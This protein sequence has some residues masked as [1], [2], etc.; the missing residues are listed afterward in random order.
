MRIAFYA[1]MKPPDDPSPSGDRLMARQ[2]LAALA[3]GGH[4]ARIV[5]RLRAWRATP[6][7]EAFA[8]LGTE[9]EAERARLAADFAAPGA[10]APDLWLTYHLYYRAPDLIGPTLAHVRR[11]PYVA[12]EASHAPKRETGPWAAQAAAARAALTGASL[13]LALTQRDRAGLAALPG[14]PPVGLF[15]PFLA[16]AGPEPPR[17]ARAGPARLVT[18]AMMRDDRKARSWAMLAEALARIAGLDWRI[19][20]AG[21]GAGRA[22]VEAAFAPLA[23]R[24]T[25]LGQL[26]AAGTRAALDRADIFVWPG[27]REAYG[28]VYLE[29]AARG[30][31]V[32]AMASGGV[33]EATRAGETALLTADEDIDAYAAAIARLIADP[34]LA[35]RLGAAGRRFAAGERSL[36]AAAAAL[37]AHLTNAITRGAKP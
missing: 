36:T 12:V 20:L 3:A 26:D 15:P 31:P 23:G 11:I 8:A 14:G 30:L 4:D 2:L 35:A 32:V 33:G 13:L 27:H 24:V 7:A 21:D 5:S 16:E 34:A 9:A 28:M 1:P 22:A 25:F 37:D 6:D 19:E 17:R 10:W 18:V 29:A